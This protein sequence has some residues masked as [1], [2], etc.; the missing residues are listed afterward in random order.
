ME[1][2]DILWEIEPHTKAKHKILEIYLK[3]WFPIMSK[4]NKKIVY[5]DGFAGPGEYINGEKGSPLLALDTAQNHIL[6]LDSE[7]LFLFIDSN[8]KC[9]ENLDRLI[10]SYNLSRNIRY[11]IIC[12]Q[13]AD[14]LNRALD[15]LDEKN[16]KIVPSF[17]M[18][19]PFGF[20][21]IPFNLIQRIMHHD[22]CEVLITFVY[23]SIN[24]FIG[25][26]QNKHHFNRMFGTTEWEKVNDLV[27]SD[28][29]TDFLLNLYISQLKHVANISF[30]RTFEMMNKYNHKVYYLIYA[31][32]HVLG[33]EKMKE[34]MW[35]VDKSGNFHFSDRTNLEQAVLFSDT[36]DYNELKR[37]V[38]RQFRGT[39]VS[40]DTIED[41]VI[42]ETAYLKKHLRNYVLKPLEQS[43]PPH[44]N[45]TGRQ[46]KST[47]PH[48][49]IVEFLNR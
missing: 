5:V 33:L 29:R 11:Q 43:D 19:D 45:V 47:Y 40:V 35:K 8:Q 42:K 10:K 38:L 41:F 48:G 30:V 2:N 22:K 9:C 27:N 26:E 32:N 37:E 20:S 7:I 31:T 24:R 17:F 28:E 21:Q 16:G 6:E 1:K 15:D 13:F 18:I 34:A 12:D 23:D 25:S 49:C 39:S 44:I 46:R 36:P 14:Y 4:L 3:A